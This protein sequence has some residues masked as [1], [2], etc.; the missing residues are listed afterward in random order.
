MKASRSGILDPLLGLITLLL[1]WQ[2]AALAMGKP[3]LPGPA[4][5]LPLFFQNLFGDLG[6]HFLASAARVILAIVM[7][8]CTA[9][10]LGLILGQAPRIN[11][12]FSPVI[13]ILYPVP[14]IVFLPV[15]YV[16]MGIS[17]IS[18]IFLISLILFFQILVVVRDEAASLTPE[19]I[20]SVRS[21]G[22]GRRALFRF[23]YLPA[24]LPA[25]LTA[26]R[27]SVGTAVAVLFIAEQALTQW[28]L[29]YYIVVETYQILLYPEMYTGILAMGLMGSLLYGLIR[30]IERKLAPHLFI[31]DME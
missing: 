30:I 29:G 25:I 10:P 9:A 18:K 14:K 7:A 12:L 1:F 24:T 20:A 19:L 31:K 28:G 23:V 22:A 6:L 17:D 8:V 11:A 2:L 27:V 16:L 4:T 21:L 15:I 13:T 26:L 3:I 5:V